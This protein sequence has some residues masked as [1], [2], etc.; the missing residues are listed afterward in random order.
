MTNKAR[1]GG[2]I[3]EHGGLT[4]RSR[5]WEKPW[6]ENHPKPQTHEGKATRIDKGKLI[7]S[8]RT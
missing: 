4:A 3:E 2:V 8:N 7:C 5:W 1:L 6:R